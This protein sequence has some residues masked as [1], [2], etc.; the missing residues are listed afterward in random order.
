MEIIQI[1]NLSID[2]LSALIKTST[3]AAITD[4]VLELLENQTVKREEIYGTRKEVAK[5]LRI[6]LPTLN[7]LTYKYNIL[8]GYRLKGRVLY[9]WAEVD[10]ALTVIETKSYLR[11]NQK[12]N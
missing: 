5:T 1:Q 10:K 6:S 8:K 12:N 3:R 9:K 11:G 7:S 2:E 4:I